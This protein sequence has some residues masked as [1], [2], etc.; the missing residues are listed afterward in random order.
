MDAGFVHVRQDRRFGDGRILGQVSAR[1]GQRLERS[2]VVVSVTMLSVGTLP[3]ILAVFIQV[4]LEGVTSSSRL[5][6]A[7]WS[8]SRVVGLIRPWFDVVRY[9]S[10]RGCVE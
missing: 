9:R 6:L 2:R 3:A 10:S 8:R 7:T 5:S 4:R 1:G